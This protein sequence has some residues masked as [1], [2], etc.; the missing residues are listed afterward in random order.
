MSPVT[1][2]RKLLS[3]VAGNAYLCN[4]DWTTKKIANSAFVL[5][6]ASGYDTMFANFMKELLVNIWNYI[7]N[8]PLFVIIILLICIGVPGLAGA[9]L[10]TF[11]IIPLI[12]ILIGFISLLRY[13]KRINSIK[14]QFQN[15]SRKRDEYSRHE[16]DGQII[17]GNRANPTELKDD[18]GEYV[19]YKEIKK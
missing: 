2:L 4:L 5:N 7:K 14:E 12:F 9:I 15:Q 1:T 13:K 3:A 16:T 11:L 18:A 19:D 10:L 17:Y 6:F 8:N